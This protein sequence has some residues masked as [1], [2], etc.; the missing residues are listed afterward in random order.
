[1]FDTNNGYVLDY[2][3]SHGVKSKDILTELHQLIK[4]ERQ[5]LIGDHVVEGFNTSG[6][7]VKSPSQGPTTQQQNC[8]DIAVDNVND[9]A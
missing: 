8:M 2:N 5:K 6:F 1:M 3:I 9:T 4:N 7:R